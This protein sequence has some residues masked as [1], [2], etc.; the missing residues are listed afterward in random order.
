MHEKP[1]FFKREDFYYHR[2]FE[3]RTWDED[4]FSQ[5]A[6]LFWR[7]E[8]TIRIKQIN[9]QEVFYASKGKVT[10][11]HCKGLSGFISFQSFPKPWN[12]L[13]DHRTHLFFSEPHLSFMTHEIITVD[14]LLRW[15]YGPSQ[16]TVWCSLLIEWCTWFHCYL[17]GG[18]YVR[19]LGHMTHA[20]LMRS[21]YLSIYVID[22]T[23]GSDTEIT[24]KDGKIVSSARLFNTHCLVSFNSDSLIHS[25][26][27]RTWIDV[28]MNFASLISCFMRCLIDCPTGWLIDRLTEVSGADGWADGSDEIDDSFGRLTNCLWFSDKGGL[29]DGCPTRSSSDGSTEGLT[30]DSTGGSS[31]GSTWDSSGSSSGSSSRGSSGC[32]EFSVVG[33]DCLSVDWF[34]DCSSGCSSDCPSGCFSS[35]LCGSERGGMSD[36]FL[37]EGMG[38]NRLYNCLLNNCSSGCSSSWLC[39]G[40]RDDMSDGCLLNEFCGIWKDFENRSEIDCRRFAA[41]HE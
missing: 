21:D 39:G 38:G 37:Y 2:R 16:Y 31:G 36:G 30:D 41:C 10:E 32:F 29:N 24:L 17:M 4:T 6:Y 14:S 20:N 40:E 5:N 15:W 8:I 25:I 3:V 13:N 34:S 19:C 26:S 33:D 22:K 9:T 28:L 12:I 35:W 7:K 11:Q 1:R 27:H 18:L 23:F